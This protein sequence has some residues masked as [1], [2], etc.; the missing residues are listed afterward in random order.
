VFYVVS[1]LFAEVSAEIR[2]SMQEMRELG[3]SYARNE[4]KAHKK[5]QIGQVHMQCV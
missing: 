5:A 3:D 2:M 4:F 1:V